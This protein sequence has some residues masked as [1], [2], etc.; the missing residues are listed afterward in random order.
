M[1]MIHQLNRSDGQPTP[2]FIRG[3]TGLIPY[4]T[5]HLELD[6][7]YPCSPHC[8]GLDVPPWLGSA[9]APAPMLELD[10]AVQLELESQ[11][12]Q[13]VRVSPCQLIFLS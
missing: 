13:D 7:G 5:A 4:A 12:N 6:Y 11:L 10:R 3:K 8:R 9:A 2:Y 1:D